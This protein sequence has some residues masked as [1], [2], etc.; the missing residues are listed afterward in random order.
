VF[1][2][3]Q[4]LNFKYSLDEYNVSTDTQSMLSIDEPGKAKS[5][6][7]LSIRFK[8][9]VIFMFQTLYPHEVS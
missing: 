7:I 4:G 2:V 1:S 9:V 6:V 8:R 3:R 5:V